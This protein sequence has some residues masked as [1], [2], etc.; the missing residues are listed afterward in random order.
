MTDNTVQIEKEA[1][2]NSSQDGRW[3]I[4]RDPRN[5]FQRLWEDATKVQK[6][7]M[8]GLAALG[9]CAAIAGTGDPDAERYSVRVDLPAPTKG[10]FVC[11]VYHG[12]R[13]DYIIKNQAVC[14]DLEYIVP[15][16]NTTVRIGEQFQV[17]GLNRG[18]FYARLA[19]EDKGY[20]VPQENYLAI[21]EA[22]LTS[23][24]NDDY[25]NPVP[26]DFLISKWN[27]ESR[28]GTLQSSPYSSAE[29]LNQFI[30]GT[31]IQ[32]LRE[33]GDLYGYDDEKAIADRIF[34]EHG[35]DYGRASKSS[36]YQSMHKR[37][38]RDPYMSAV[39]G[40]HNTIR[41]LQKLQKLVD[42]GE[43]ITP[44]RDENGNYYL[45]AKDAY[46][47]HFLGANETGAVKFFEKLRTHAAHN[48]CDI[49]EGGVCNR[50]KYFFVIDGDDE[51]LIKMKKDKDYGLGKHTKLIRTHNG[52]SYVVPDRQFDGY[53]MKERQIGTNSNGDP[54]YGRV[55]VPQIHLSVEEFYERM[56][57]RWGFT[58]ERMPDL[59]EWNPREFVPTG[60]VEYPSESFEVAQDNLRPYR[61]ATRYVTAD[62]VTFT[63]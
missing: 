52:E 47:G 31:G 16:R 63:M 29:G 37:V 54:V 43:M 34:R 13:S 32:L 50:N 14:D 33:A 19:G 8:L 11:G 45:T 1:K 44:N 26:F 46:I 25:A 2:A 4:K 27:L 51:Q 3:V 60:S 40:I 10:E 12:E 15:Q 48:M 53:K 42:D 56:G 49:F 9:G 35:S 57:T 62:S 61:K 22:Y 58:D 20:V 28:L 5:S 7:A 36:E 55:R 41:G 59:S 23:M 21:V 17:A 39:I 30:A 6:G 24:G 18:K 38:F